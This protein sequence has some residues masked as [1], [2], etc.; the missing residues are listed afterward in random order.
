MRPVALNVV[1][2]TEAAAIAASRWV[3]SGN[4]E[5]AD[6]AAT[7]AL[8][9]RLNQLDIYG[10]VILTVSNTNQVD[11]SNEADGIYIMT[12]SAEGFKSTTKRISLLK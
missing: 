5:E 1:R 2:A 12:I 3:G 8:R 6:R 7:I 9:E 4:K 11:L 10:K